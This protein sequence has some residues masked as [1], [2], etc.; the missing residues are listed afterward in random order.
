M[1]ID[2]DLL[3]FSSATRPGNVRQLENVIA[4]L[5][6]IARGPKLTMRD[7]EIDTT[8]YD[9]LAEFPPEPLAVENL[10]TLEKRQIVKALQETNRN[11]LKAAKLLGISRATIFRKI[12]EYGLD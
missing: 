8:L 4:R 2:D 9:Q 11:R 12:R 5:A 10:A 3:A 6:I 7:L 1:S